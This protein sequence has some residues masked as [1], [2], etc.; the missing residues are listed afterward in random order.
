M[1]EQ[2]V[3]LEKLI[4]MVRALKES[5]NQL[6]ISLEA[7]ENELKKF[8]ETLESQKNIIEDLKYQLKTTKLAN[9]IDNID[10]EEKATL[11]KQF[12]EYIR[13]IDQIIEFLGKKG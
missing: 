10:L 6:K 11:K 3:Q 4:S 1:K 5:E 8:T 2:F 9:Q 12:S 7:R 13:E